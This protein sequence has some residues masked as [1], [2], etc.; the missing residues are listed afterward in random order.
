MTHRFITAVILAALAALAALACTDLDAGA[1]ATRPQASAGGSTMPAA[2]ASSDLVARGAYLAILGNCA[3]CHTAPGEAAYAGGAGV[4]TPFGTVYPG[5]LTPDVGTGLGRWQAD[6]FWQALHHG[7]SRDGRRLLPAFPY[8]SYTHVRREDSDALF[9]YL[10]SLPAVSQANRPHALR[11]PYNSQAAIALWQWLHFSPATPPPA[12]SDA[13][14]VARG[15]YLVQGLGHCAACHAP[16]NALGAPATDARGADMP[17]HAWYAP[18]LHPTLEQPAT[19]EE[20]V[21][22]LGSGRSRRATVSGPMAS[23]VFRSMQHWTDADLRATARYLS[24]LA[25]ETIGIIEAAG[26]AALRRGAQVY[27]RRC[28]DCH[29]AQGEGRAGAYPALAGNATVQQPG[30]RN[31]VRLMRLGS[32]GPATSGNP[33]PHSM[34]HQGLSHADMAAVASF[35]RQSWGNRASAITEIEVMNLQ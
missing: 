14:P 18:T 9:A 5:N 17:G 10:Q 2:Q 16:R 28:A 1:Q 7:R 27:D 21:Q 29:G 35:V 19:V 33:L 22:L 30:A 4:A 26:E 23:V 6:D 31:M 32:F 11:F 25:P 20:L 34:P 15:A 24:R 3:G 13:D 12:S 8:T